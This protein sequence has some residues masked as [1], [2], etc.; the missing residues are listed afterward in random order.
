MKLKQRTVWSVSPIAVVFGALSFLLLFALLFVNRTVFWVAAAVA[1][2]VWGY[3]I[4]RLLYVKRDIRRYLVSIADRLNQQDRAALEQTPVPVAVVSDNSEIIWYND[5]FRREVLR[6][7][8][9]LGKPLED[10]FADLSA[11]KLA[12][13]VLPQV[14]CNQRTYAVYVNKL[15]V[16]DEVAYVLYCF[17]HTELTHIAAEYELSRPVVLSLCLDNSD[18]VMKTLRDSERAQLFSQVDILLEDWANAHNGLFRKSRSDRFMIVLEQRYLEQIKH[19]R[20]DILD[21]VRA[22]PTADNSRLTLSVGVGSGKTLLEAD[23]QAI[24]MLDMA[25][26]RGGDQAVVKTQ[27]GFDFYGGLSKSVEKRTKVRSRVIAAALQQMIMESDMV[28]TMG[29][30]YSDLDCL[31]SAVALTAACRSLGKPAYTV[32]DP[33][34]TLAGALVEYYRQNG[35][36]DVF[37]ESDAVLPRMTDKTLLIITDI[38]QPERLDMPAIYQKAEIVAVIDH[39]RKMV[40]H[41]DDAVLFYHEPYSSSASELVTEILQYMSGVTV[42]R[43]E[44]EAL[45]SGIMLDTRHFVMKAGVR[46]FEAAAYLRKLGAD[47]VEVKRLFSEDMTVYQRKAEIVSAAESYRGMAIAWAESGG[48]GMRIAASQAA[49]ELLCVKEVEASFVMFVENGGVN[50]S[51]RSYGEINVQLIME[52]VGGGGHQTMAGA[53]L[54]DTDL[55]AATT[56]LHK[57]VD[58]YLS[59]RER[60]RAAQK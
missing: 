5:L 37:A 27:N 25:L 2:P 36:G 16:H 1:V 58:T 29:H 22:I 6:S 8:E 26:G 20:F 39:H 33:Q 23:L 59:E 13:R 24:Q 52:A 48:T 44:A 21:K 35:K 50:I 42:S 45:L 34:T 54:K 53:Y 32:Y 4:W 30:R 55:A 9:M 56:L 14:S 12:G 15:R 60:A 17:D 46:T 47:T 28:I 49:D 3:G 43:L 31:G 7:E 57:A 51:A 10:V 11:G 40:E 38:H 41:I 19:D 18:E